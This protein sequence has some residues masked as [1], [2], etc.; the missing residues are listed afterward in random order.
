MM[1]S[2][3]G[4]GQTVAGEEFQSAGVE[5]AVSAVVLLLVQVSA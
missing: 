5:N 2:E 3:R 1:A 4:S